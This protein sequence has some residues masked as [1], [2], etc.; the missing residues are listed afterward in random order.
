M[1]PSHLGAWASSINHW[2]HSFIFAKLEPQMHFRGWWYWERSP[3]ENRDL[4]MPPDIMSGPYA[5]GPFAINLDINRGRMSKET[6][7]KT[8]LIGALAALVSTS[9]YAADL[10]TQEPVAPEVVEAAPISTWDG[11][12]IGALG[13]AG[14]LQGDYDFGATTASRT[15]AGGLLGAF[16]GYNYQLDN[17]VVLGVEGDFSYNWNKE[18]IGGTDVGTDWAGS[19]RGRV[20]YAFDDALIYGTAGWTTARGFVDAPG[21]SKQTKALNG[22]TVGAGVDYKITQNIFARA[23]Y[24]FND[25]GTE[26]IGGVKFDNQQHQAII[27][28]GYKF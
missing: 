14:W 3:Y 2:E 17:N 24:R 23:E 4:H 18:S 5:C 22:Y 20:G 8:L 7:M 15:K 6:T 12:Y 25:Y 16:A 1:P 26:K 13:G 27:G 19:A 28:I 10:V 21:A 9:A 11:A